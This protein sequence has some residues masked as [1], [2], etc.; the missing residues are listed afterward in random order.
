MQT[1]HFSADLV[2]VGGGL[3]GTACAVTAARAGIK[4][5]LLQDRPVLGGNASSEVR[6][7]V[8]GAT[9][10]MGNNNRWAREGGF[11]DELLL[12]NLYRNPE[13]NPLIFDTIILEK[14]VAEGNIT[15]LLNTA[16][17]SVDKSDEETITSVTAFCS[18]NA[19][20]YTAA[21]PL[22]CD[23]S[24]DGILG[25]L[26]G[27]A[28]RM[29]AEKKE[30][31]GEKF[32]PSVAYGELLG[33]SIYF[34]TKDVGKPVRFVPPAYALQ[35]ITQIPRYRSFNAKDYGCKLW[36]IEYGGRLD[37]VHQSEAIKWELWKVVYGVWNY[38]KNSGKF[39]EAETM[40]LEWVGTIP[41]KRE[42][43][44]FEGDYIL[45]QQDIIEQRPHHDT[46]AFGGWSVDLHPADGVFSE[47]PGCN[48]WH[49]KGIYS[50]PFRCLYSRNL[51]NLFLAG[52]TI[53]ASHVAFGSTRVMGT[54]AHVG[55][56]VG[57]AAALCVQKDCTIR[58]LGRK[59]KIGELQQA[60]LRTGHHL[61]NICLQDRE[62]LVQK[63]TVRATSVFQLRELPEGEE[64]FAL[65][66][67]AAQMLPVTKGKMPALSV[68]VQAS[69]ETTLRLQFRC[70]SKPYNHS[71]DTTLKTIDVPLKKGHQVIE[72][73]ED[74]EVCDDGYLY[75]CFLKN[76][77]VQLCY[78]ERRVSGVLSL[79][80]KTNA[81]VSNYGRQD[82]PEDIG[83]EA[84]E[85]WCPDRR[86]Y[87]K[88]I[89]M[90]VQGNAFSFVAEAVRNGIF[91]PAV[92]PNAWVAK[93]E[94][95][96]PAITIDWSEPQTIR[97][98]VLHFDTDFDHPLESVLMTHPETESPFCVA[99]FII[100][101][102]KHERVFE[103]RNNHQSVVAVHFDSPLTTR[104]LTLH[105]ERK[106]ENVPAALFG[107]RCYA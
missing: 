23:A 67:S 62:D 14:V 3:S 40:T 81:A 87:G 97:R 38:I 99:H 80:N 88:N 64:W 101:N 85:F 44:R 65:A 7:W 2:V 57:M 48:Q 20:Q 10:H 37:T 69:E 98:L 16:V 103:M 75:I 15:L 1:V 106:S 34:Y 22:F 83:V 77:A 53:S 24:G 79:F 63:A 66:D 18:Q 54:S 49:S 17:Y 21:A 12:E 76:K 47:R 45:T 9:S 107:V 59:E 19:T 6:L 36:W 28:F 8:L 30:E 31:F 82:P 35:D 94:E 60:L 70:S 13:G 51:K 100:C 26:A 72:L 29:G 25:F 74:L 41:G 61:P 56:A 58:V 4:V 93:P 73:A 68:P 32:A 42:S 50:I 78:S 90:K 27:A 52:R 33:H 71:P 96:K 46:V 92:L 89:A 95:E 55:Q 91:R 104:S 86:P 43:R 11:I 84:F 105:L 39:P 5:I 102:D